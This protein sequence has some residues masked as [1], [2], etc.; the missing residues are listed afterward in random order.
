[1]QEVNNT[2]LC[3]FECPSVVCVCEPVTERTSTE[4]Q[5]S[6]DGSVQM[7]V[8][9]SLGCEVMQNNNVDNLSNETL[10]ETLII[11]NLER[12]EDRELSQGGVEMWILW[13][14]ITGHHSL[15]PRHLLYLA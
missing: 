12:E 6:P 9:K 13:V 14:R 3:M 1:M 8:L 7:E 10:S 4:N 15:E 11:G 2:G 5:P